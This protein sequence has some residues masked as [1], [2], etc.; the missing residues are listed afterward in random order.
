MISVSSYT[1]CTGYS[2]LGHLH[3]LAFDTIKI[4]Q[5]FIRQLDDPRCL[6]I[7]RAV[8]GMASALDF[9]IVAEGVETQKQFE[10]LRELGAH[11]A[12]GWLVG[13]PQSVDEALAAIKA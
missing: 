13:K 8:V 6:A 3:K 1:L 5:G 2:N 10:Q 12:Q 7:V 9:A 4:D 11:Y